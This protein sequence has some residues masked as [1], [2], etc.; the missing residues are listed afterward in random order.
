MPLD[1]LSR[2]AHPGLL[3]PARGVAA[4]DASRP[5][6]QRAGDAQRLADLIIDSAAGNEDA[7]AELYDRTHREAHLC[8]LRILRSP[9]HT[10][11][12]LQEAYL[13]IWLKS[14][15]YEVSRGSTMGWIRMIV[16]RRA[17]DRV[18]QVTSASAR[19]LADAERSHM[20]E[21]GDVGDEVASRVDALRIRG[22]LALLSEVQGEAVRLKYLEGRSLKDIAAQLDLPLS[23]VKSR[24]R[25]ALVRLRSTVEPDRSSAA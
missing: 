7:F 5:V 2:L 19:E 15:S 12:V 4:D 16:T 11:E 10:V 23:T 20:T 25:D 21:V 18:R 8:A 9:A 6:R 1:T 3:V 14:A 17:I 24:L 22:A 13:E